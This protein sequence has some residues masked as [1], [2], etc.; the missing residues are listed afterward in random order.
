MIEPI[1]PIQTKKYHKL[2]RND[3]RKFAHSFINNN[4]N[5]KIAYQAIRPT[6]KDARAKQQ[7]MKLLDDVVVRAEIKT[8]LENNGITADY[9]IKGYKV[10]LEAGLAKKA[11]NRDAIVVLSELAKLSGIEQ[12]PDLEP[13]ERDYLESLSRDALLTRLDKISKQVKDLKTEGAIEGDIE[14][15]A[16]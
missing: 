8:L 6:V 4:N 9:I 13:L 5:S 7:G 3:K 14:P 2:T 1:K 11:T 10:A 15:I 16:E 12:K